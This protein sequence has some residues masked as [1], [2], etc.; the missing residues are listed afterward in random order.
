MQDRKLEAWMS[1]CEQEK[2]FPLPS[3]RLGPDSFL[4]NFIFVLLCYEFLARTLKGA[5]LQ[6]RRNQ[7]FSVNGQTVT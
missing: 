3:E 4:K 5:D 7:L 6:S 1:F 2:C